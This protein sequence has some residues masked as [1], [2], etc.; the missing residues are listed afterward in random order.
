M[1]LAEPGCVLPMGPYRA[2][3]RQARAKAISFGGGTPRGMRLP[4]LKASA[5]KWAGCGAWLG[6]GLG[7]EKPT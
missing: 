5:V 3:G 6:L 7:S 2:S 4:L 1:P